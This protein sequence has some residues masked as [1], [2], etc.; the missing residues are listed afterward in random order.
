MRIVGILLVGVLTSCGS[1]VYQDPNKS[2][3]A[4]TESTKGEGETPKPA[5]PPPVPPEPGPTNVIFS[6]YVSAAFELTVNDQV[7]VDSEDFYTQQLGELETQAAEGGYEGWELKFEAEIGLADLKNGMRVYVVADEEKGYAKET[8]VKG[9]GTF[10]VEFP[11][12][13]TGLYK[14][15]ANKRVGVTLTNPDPQAAA[16][17]K[18]VFWC[19]NFSAID[20]EVKLEERDKPIILD[21]F[22][23][24][25]TR[26]KCSTSSSGG[27]TIP[28]KA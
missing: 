28:P 2:S 19:Y 4:K 27:I 21:K 14:V 25:I 1:I 5:E 24:K 22:V 13:G 12:D 8:D 17:D 7:Y 11:P 20:K 10:S 18:E 23:T 6:G 9:D 16:A 26:Y 3:S 15:R